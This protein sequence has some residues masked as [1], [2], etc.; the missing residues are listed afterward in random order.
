MLLVVALWLMDRRAF[1]PAAI[2]CGLASAARP[3]AA[4]IIGV[5]MLAYWFNR[6]DSAGR[7]LAR[8]A[9]L[10]LVASGGLFGYAAY[11]A[12]RFGSPLVYFTNFRA[13]WVRDEA[14]A[15][16]FEYLTL[17]RVWDQFKYIGRLVEDFPVGLVNAT[18]SFL[19]EYPDYAVHPVPQPGRA[20]T[21]T[22]QL[23]PAAGA[24]ADYLP[25]RVPGV[26]RGD[27]RR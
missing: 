16:W 15:S 27:V 12:Y 13:G 5:L 25:A 21:G 1:V 26:G 24:G 20:G 3:T 18:H 17:A 19:L 10:S 14:R 2:V 4:G 22:T 23:S 11:L 9:P 6:G 7:R 8:L